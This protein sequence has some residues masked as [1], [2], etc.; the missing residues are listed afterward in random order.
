MTLKFK[1]KYKA[2]VKVSRHFCATFYLM[3]MFGNSAFKN[4]K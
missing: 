4:L 2:A 3:F 1:T